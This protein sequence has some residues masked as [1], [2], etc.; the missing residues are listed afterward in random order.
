MA[1]EET[2]R[3]S[4]SNNLAASGERFTEK[5]RPMVAQGVLQ[6]HWVGQ[7]GPRRGR[8]Q[9]ARFFRGTWRGKRPRLRKNREGVEHTTGRN[10]N[11]SGGG[12]M[13]VGGGG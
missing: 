9:P 12:K 8:R 7:Q 2:R 1:G 10:E 11:T 13:G 6:Q 5:V 3:F 4:R